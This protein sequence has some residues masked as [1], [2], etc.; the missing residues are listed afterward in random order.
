MVVS[1]LQKKI[2]ELEQ[3]LRD[4][5]VTN[6]S[7]AEAKAREG[8]RLK[9]EDAE[10]VS[11]RSSLRPDMARS[12][13][14]VHA[15]FSSADPDET[16][17][18]TSRSRDL[19]PRDEVVASWPSLPI[20]GASPSASS[21]S[22]S[23]RSHNDA[24]SKTSSSIHLSHLT[25]FK[26]ESPDLS[27]NVLS[28]EPAWEPTPME[29][30][31]AALLEDGWPKT[32]PDRKTCKLLLKAFFNRPL[33]PYM[34]MDTSKLLTRL[35]LAPSHPLFPQLSLLHAILAIGTTEVSLDAL[36]PRPYWS[37]NAGGPAEYHAQ[38]ADKLC[39]EALSYE[40]EPRALHENAQAAVVLGQWYQT[41]GM[42]LLLWKSL[43][44]ALR[45]CTMLGYSEASLWDP[46]KR[47]EWDDGVENIGPPVDGVDA[48]ERCVGET[49]PGRRAE[50]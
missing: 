12:S 6:A 17:L 7:A 45:V 30:E 42:A 44:Y 22:G 31:A 21:T 41:K 35:H 18:A 40:R 48:Y 26:N 25:P 11:R 10:T 1:E 37:R 27:P 5:K 47:R 9:V 2:D 38:W 13:S 36:G 50:L 24:S 29:P 20:N 14:S 19:T 32:L 46:N 4:M 43:G 39:W 23:S 3:Q 15:V 16:L 49:L 28:S 33:A 8:K 34:I